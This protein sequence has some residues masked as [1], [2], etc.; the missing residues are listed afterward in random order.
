MDLSSFLT[1]FSREYINDRD[2]DA[3]RE[4]LVPNPQAQK[5]RLETINSLLSESIQASEPLQ[6]PPIL[7]R[8]LPE[9]VPIQHLPP[10]P[11]PPPLPPLSPNLPPVPSLPP[12]EEL[13]SLDFSWNKAELTGNTHV[14]DTKFCP[15]LNEGV[16]CK[17]SDKKVRYEYTQRQ[18]QATLGATPAHDIEQLRTLL[19]NQLVDG[20]RKNRN[21]WVE[22]D[23]DI[24]N[25]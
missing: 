15:E 23:T 8:R 17:S 25:G 21:A 5:C 19:R 4:A 9:P 2:E 1:C 7:S 14:I 18:R 12:P 13:Q 16:P 6:L 20:K 11:P 10:P 22:M 24:L 3:W